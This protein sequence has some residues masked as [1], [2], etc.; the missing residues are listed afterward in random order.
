MEGTF[1]VE[2]S[3][4]FINSGLEKLPIRIF[5]VFLFFVFIPHNEHYVAKYSA[6]STTAL[7]DHVKLIT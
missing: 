7:N 3:I 2:S 5:P 1:A 6:V 4:C